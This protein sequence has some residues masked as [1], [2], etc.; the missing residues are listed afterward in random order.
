MARSQVCKREGPVH[1][2]L[3]E[4]SDLKGCVSRGARDP[5]KVTETEE[6]G[7]GGQSLAP[8]LRTLSQVLGLR[9]V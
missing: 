3:L 5:R 4:H 7:R 1:P 8:W 9:A 2:E 6:K